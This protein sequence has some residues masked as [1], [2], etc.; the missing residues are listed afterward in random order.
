ME[1]L[2]LSKI[3]ENLVNYGIIAFT[4]GMDKPCS[5]TDDTQMSIATETS[6]IQSKQLL[7]E[8]EIDYLLQAFYQQ[9][10]D[11]LCT[12]DKPSTF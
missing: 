11:W 5:Y 9:Y 4:L 8:K 10:L 7:K 12:I 3:K 1:L 2:S 6:Y